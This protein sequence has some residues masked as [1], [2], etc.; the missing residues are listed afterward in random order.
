MS[1]R[2]HTKAKPARIAIPARAKRIPATEAKNRFGDILEKVLRGTPAVITKHGDAKALLISI[3]AL[4][5]LAEIPQT[6]LNSLTA[7]FDQLLE[8][9]QGEKAGRAMQ[10]AFDASP[11]E[12][13]QAASRGARRR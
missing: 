11:E 2:N 12:I 10:A 7:E 4:N 3:E 9:M 8:D 1:A 13:G 5:T 6:E